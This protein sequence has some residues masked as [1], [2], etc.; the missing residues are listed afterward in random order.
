[1]TRWC[2]GTD[3]EE[4]AAQETGR[5]L[6]P[7]RSSSLLG[8]RDPLPQLLHVV[9]QVP[10][11]QVSPAAQVDVHPKGLADASHFRQLAASS[12]SS[13]TQVPLIAHQPPLR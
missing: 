9:S 11:Q 7:V 10:A 4:V 6:L 3:E 2:S 12:V 1:M 13:A 8:F 5:G